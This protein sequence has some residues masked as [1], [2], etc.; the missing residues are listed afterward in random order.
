MRIIPRTLALLLLSLLLLAGCGKREEEVAVDRQAGGDA[1]ETEQV[2][3]EAEPADEGLVWLDYA[4]GVGKAK[5]EGR[6]VLIDFWTTWCHWCKVMDK[7][8]Y[9]HAAVIAR[10]EKDFVA[11]KVNAEGKSAIGGEGGM[12]GEQLARAF[13]VDSYPTTWFLDPEG[14]KVAPLA[15]YMPPEEFLVV[16][17]FI[18]TRSY[19]GMSF[20]AYRDS[21]SKG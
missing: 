21:L 10:L 5:A 8:T 7:E 15:G 11:V 13:G 9:A 4:S 6:F 17:G 1:I 2:T 19:T 16:L 12:S 14:G 20:Q 18:S 3:A